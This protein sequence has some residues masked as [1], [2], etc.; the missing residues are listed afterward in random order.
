M[1]EKL[2]QKWMEQEA[3][4]IMVRIP[5]NLNDPDQVRLFVETVKKFVTD[6]GI[7]QTALAQEIGVSGTALSQFLAGKYPG[8]IESVVKGLAEFINRSC[9]RSRRSKEP[10]YVET[11]VAKRILAA[12]R[13]TEQFTTPHEGRICLIVGDA[14][15]GKT[16]C[17]QQYAK[18]N[19][20]ATY[21]K[22]C[23]KMSAA[24]MMSRIAEALKL[25]ADGGLKKLVDD[26]TKELRQREVTIILDEAAGLDV[27]RLNLLRQVIVENGCTLVLAGNT[28]LLKTLNESSMRRGNECL[29]QFRSRMLMAL[30]LDEMAKDTPKDGGLYGVEDIR[31]LYADGGIRLT[32]GAEGLL[33]SIARCPLTGRLRTCSVI[34]ASINTS[35]QARDGRIS[36]ISAELILDTITQLRLPVGPY[37]PMAIERAAAAEVTAQ[38]AAT[39]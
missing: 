25:D 2:L 14:G 16:K 4:K 35:R 24:A 20:L 38:A 33:M 31:K 8:K 9:R 1:N 11:T 12:I 19:P 34:V 28:H 39:A 5:Q 30:N 3:R 37:L 17:L 27:G 10:D 18:V 6:T 29:D 21:V 23:D 26:L 13:V 36:E 22:L 7:S 32:G 15:H